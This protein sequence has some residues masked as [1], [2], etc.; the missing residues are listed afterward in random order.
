MVHPSFSTSSR[1][2]TKFQWKDS[3]DAPSPKNDVSPFTMHKSGRRG[4]MLTKRKLSVQQTLTL[5][6]FAIFSFSVVSNI[7]RNN[8]YQQNLQRNLQIKRR[9]CAS[10]QRK[11]QAAEQE[12]GS[13]DK[14][15]KGDEYKNGGSKFTDLIDRVLVGTSVETVTD[16]DCETIYPAEVAVMSGSDYYIEPD[17]ESSGL[18][19]SDEIPAP[20]VDAE[21][22]GT[23][24]EID[25]VILD[26]D[27]NDPSAVTSVDT[28]LLD[29]FEP[30]EY[31]PVNETT[32]PQGTTAYT[33]VISSCPDDY[34]PPSSEVTDPGN[35][36]FEA[37]AMLKQFVCNVTETTVSER[38]RQRRLRG[39]QENNDTSE[40]ESIANYTM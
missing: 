38:R 6:I 35:D 22:Q 23:Q 17:T 1:R 20:V 9:L 31:N 30:K 11:L 3:N 19:Y 8:I 28:N 32:R 18:T 13:N 36:I 37:S 33:V 34:N 27:A 39:L 40:D 2:A 21:L 26:P 4:R 14:N 10:K 7:V 16:E 29:I 12:E 15:K 5:V 25:P 24:E